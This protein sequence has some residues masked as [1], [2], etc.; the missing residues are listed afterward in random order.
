M[1]K[2]IA[3]II[4][5][6]LLV[7]CILPV[8][9]LAG[10]GDSD[11]TYTVTF[12]SE[13]G[14]DVSSQIIASGD[15][16]T[17]PTAPTDTRIES[18]IGI[19]DGWYTDETFNTIWD[20]DNTV[21]GNITLYA[22]YVYYDKNEYN[23]LK[24]FLNADSASSGKNGAQINSSYSDADP[25]TWGVIWTKDEENAVCHVTKIE[26][27]FSKNLKGDLDLSGLSALADL[28]CSNNKISSIN[29]ADDTALQVL[30]CNGNNLTSLDTS[31]AGSS[32]ETIDRDHNTLT[33]L[34]LTG[35]TGLI[36][37]ECQ[38]NALTSLTVSGAKLDT[39]KCENN[40]ISGTLNLTN[41]TNLR[42]LDC[43]SNKIEGLTLTNC[44]TLWKLYC[45]NN[46]ISSLSIGDCWNTLN[47]LECGD[48]QL[49]ALNVS[50]NTVLQ[51]LDC[52]DN[53]IGTLSLDANTALEKLYCSGDSLISLNL[54]NN[55][56]LTELDCSDNALDSL[57]VSKNDSLTLLNCSGCGIKTLNLSNN[58]TLGALLCSDNSLSTLDLSVSTIKK[59]DCTDNP[60]TDIKAVV[61]ATSGPNTYPI[62]LTANGNGYVGYYFMSSAKD[63][64]DIGT[65]IMAYPAT[66]VTFAKWTNASGTSVATTAKYGLSFNTAYSLAA[67]FEEFHYTIT[68]VSG[69]TAYG[70]VSGGGSYTPGTSVT[71]T[72][73]PDSGYYFT[74]WYNG[75]TL[76]S[77]NAVYTFTAAEDL[78]LTAQFD[79]IQYTITAESNNP[80][81][82]SISGGGKFESGASVTLTAT[83]KTGYYFTGWYDGECIHILY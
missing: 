45:T 74:G 8:T 67:K 79:P 47:L 69:N 48:N 72:A 60:L 9:V 15:K 70:S 21:S 63:E 52:S 5:F 19:L 61:A 75:T 43:D 40:Q 68:A 76:V 20:F 37:L 18:I 13:G 78:T 17:K 38:N 71:L 83:P 34:T 36:D 29:L 44:S 4:I 23:K 62:E 28:D 64:A 30:L 73:T 26:E 14:S 33:T 81:Y 80:A 51:Y 39:L 54:N 46:K 65:Y 59:L 32:L 35:N 55:K 77:S 3:A 12:N 25:T 57:R 10:A 16:V 1:K 6:V 11:G 82:G 50:S 53:P 56:A 24:Q 7:V 49:T 27:W 42:T 2:K 58:D 22:K 66:G 31:A 41:F